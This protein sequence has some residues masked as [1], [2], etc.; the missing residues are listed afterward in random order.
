MDEKTSETFPTGDLLS[1]TTGCLLS[2]TRIDGV[3]RIVDYMTGVPHF[4]HQLPRGADAIK[5]WLIEQHPWLADITSGWESV[6]D[7]TT[8]AAFCAEISARYGE[9]HEVNPMPVGAYTGRDPLNEL[10]EM[11]GPNRIIPVVVA[12]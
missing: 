2:P 3:Y 9:F 12:D 10:A 6:K 1:I 8:A 4:T 5:S 11:I 7:D